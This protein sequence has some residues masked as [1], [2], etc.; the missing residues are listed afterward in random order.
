MDLT[1]SKKDLLRLVAKMQGVA[2]RRST[3]PILS[4]VLLAASSNA[5]TASAT[6][7]YL[8]L[9]GTVQADTGKPGSVAVSAKALFDRVKM[10][11]DGP[12]TLTSDAKGQTTLKAKGSARRYTLRGMPGDDFPPLAKDESNGDPMTVD[13]G[14]LLTLIA[15]SHYAVSADESRPHLS[16]A[17]FECDGKVIRMVATDGHR[18]SVAEV[19]AN[20][21][22]A[23]AA[24][25]I[26]SKAVGELRRMC[27]EAQAGPDESATVSITQSGPCAFVRGN[28][29]TFSVKLVGAQFPPYQQ[30][31]PKGQDKLATVTRVAFAEALKAVSVASNERTGGVKLVLTKGNLRIS[32]ESPEGGD[33]FDELPVEYAGPSLTIGLN[34]KYALDVLAC[35]ASD[36]LVLGFGGELDPCTI[37][38]PGDESFTAVVM[39]MRA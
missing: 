18:L 2:E 13:A 11:P 8:A 24:M 25:L 20:G 15:R 27:E 10:M 33:G 26:P 37:R 7:L 6:D 9:T 30:V 32:S 28:G 29:L 1:V 34:A 16:S 12:V 38:M 22:T 4:N 17:L 23:R 3:M 35:L 5:M 14:A 31:I 36:D 19:P 39:P 21:A